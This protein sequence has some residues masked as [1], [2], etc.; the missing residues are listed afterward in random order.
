[1]RKQLLLV[2]ALLPFAAFARDGGAAMATFGAPLAGAGVTVST[3]TTSITYS[4]TNQPWA[5]FNFT[6]LSPDALGLGPVVGTLTSVS[7]DAVLN[8]STNFTYAN[9]LTIYVDP[10]PLSTGGLL[11]VGGFSNLSAA[12]RYIWVDGESDIP[13]TTVIESYTLVAPLV[14]T[15]GPA[16][17]AIW[18]GNGYG[19]AGTSGTWTGTVTLTGIAPIPEPS[20]WLLMALGGIGLAGWARRRRAEG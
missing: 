18:L 8:A 13:G 14:F 16:D 2:A 9:D 5:G 1:M 4:F 6:Q 3:T 12:E 11:Q 7:V 19:A 10:L 15:G 20:T 17:P